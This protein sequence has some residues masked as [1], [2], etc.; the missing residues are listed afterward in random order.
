MS[1]LNNIG[2]HYSTITYFERMLSNL[3]G[4]RD[5]LFLLEFD[6]YRAGR[7]ILLCNEYV[8]SGSAIESF[9][10]QFGR[11]DIVC[12]GGNWN[13]W[14]EEA[15]EVARGHGIKLGKFKNIRYLLEK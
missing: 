12:V 8:L 1:E 11:F 5:V 2:V 4:V 10:H 6:G 15:F 9:I 3:P 14:S 13:S 7:S